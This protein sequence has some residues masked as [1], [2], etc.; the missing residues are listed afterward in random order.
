[1]YAPNMCGGYVVCAFNIYADP[2][3][4][5]LVGEYRSQHEYKYYQDPEHHEFFLEPEPSTY[6]M[7]NF[8]FGHSYA[9]LLD[10][11][12]W[13]F[14]NWLTYEPMI[15]PLMPKPFLLDWTGQLLRYPKGQDYTAPQQCGDEGTYYLP[16]DL[17]KDCHVDFKDFAEFALFW[18]DCTDPNDPTCF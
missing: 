11:E 17:N 2:G 10:D 14:N 13:K 5:M 15:E 1:M 3:G 12:L 4:S 9:L 7:G 8:R 18:L 16:A 6:F